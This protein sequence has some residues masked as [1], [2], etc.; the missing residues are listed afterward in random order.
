MSL[1]NRIGNRPLA[2]FVLIRRLARKLFYPRRFLFRHELRTV[3]QVRA[4]FI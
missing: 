2:G 1:Q 3:N 4:A